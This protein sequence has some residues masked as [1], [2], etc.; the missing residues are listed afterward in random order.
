MPSDVPLR[1]GAY[2]DPA[3]V[4]ARVWRELLQVCRAGHTGYTHQWHRRALTGGSWWRE[5][6]MA[7]VD[8]PVQAALATAMGWRYFRT[9]GTSGGGPAAGELHCPA[10]ARDAQCA[11]CQLCRGRGGLATR[12]PSVW[13]ATH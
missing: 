9:D 8:S 4:P 7:S 10:V 12:A 5:H 11:T 3:A 1:I 2:G 13:I 6:M